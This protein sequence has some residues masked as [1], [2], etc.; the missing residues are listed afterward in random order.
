M[1]K[2]AME[3]LETDKHN[4][5]VLYK[6][7]KKIEKLQKKHNLEISAFKKKIEIELEMLQKQKS[8]EQ[9]K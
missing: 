3:K 5:E 4:K 8:T 6:N 1:K 2:Q 9:G 7:K